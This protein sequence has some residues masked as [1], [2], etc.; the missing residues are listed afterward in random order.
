MTLEC[1]E[2]RAEGGTPTRYTTQKVLAA[3]HLPQA[4]RAAPAGLRSCRDCE[5]S[6]NTTTDEV[7]GVSPWDET[8]RGVRRTAKTPRSG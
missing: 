3:Q 6:S 4:V 7:D 1:T 2:A 8:M 5:Y